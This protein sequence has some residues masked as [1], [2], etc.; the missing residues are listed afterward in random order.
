M[1]QPNFPPIKSHETKI[2][3]HQIEIFKTIKKQ[4]LIMNS[5]W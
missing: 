4:Y 3:D 1:P 2:D 5:Y